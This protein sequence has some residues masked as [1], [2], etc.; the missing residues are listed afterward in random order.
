MNNQVFY[1]IFKFFKY[2]F[3]SILTL[4]RDVKGLLLLA[5][6]KR[7]ISYMDKNQPSVAQ[8]F[9]KWVK[10]QPNKEFIVFN[11]TIWTFQEVIFS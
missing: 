10:K 4:R 8:V 1:S 9:S 7:K 2:V 3:F 5:R 6:T 11:D